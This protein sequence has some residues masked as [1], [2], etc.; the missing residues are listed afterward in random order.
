MEVFDSARHG[1]DPGERRGGA[2]QSL[3]Q[4]D[5]FLDPRHDEKRYRASPGKY[6]S[7]KFVTI[8]REV[9]LYTQQQVVPH[10]RPFP[11]QDNLWCGILTSLSSYT[12]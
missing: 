6:F 2:G 5:P 11:Q 4:A 9:R 12:S 8:E 10:Q 1:S 7:G 3:I